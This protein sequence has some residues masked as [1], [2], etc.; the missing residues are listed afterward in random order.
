MSTSIVLRF[1]DLNVHLHA[2][3]K[4]LELYGEFFALA[5]GSG[6]TEEIAAELTPSPGGRYQLT[7]QGK[8]RGSDLDAGAALHKLLVTLR[9][10]AGSTDNGTL[11]RASA[12][13]WGDKSVLI[14]G[15]VTESGNIAAWLVAQ[16]FSYISQGYVR[17]DATTGRIEGFAGPMAI[18]ERALHE[19]GHMDA[20]RN[21]PSLR[22]RGAAY[23]RP[24]LG[25][26]PLETLSQ[27]ALILDVRRTKGTE[28]RL[29]AADDE[30][31]PTRLSWYSEDNAAANL[32]RNQ[33]ASALL[34]TVPT[35]SLEYDLVRAG[36]GIVD[37]FV[38]YV[39]EEGMTRQQVASLMG[40]MR[41]TTPDRVASDGKVLAPTSRKPSFRPRLTIGMATFDDYDGAYFSVQALRMYHPEVVD[42]AEILMIDNNPRGASA[43]YLKSLEKYADH[44]R[45][46]PEP[47]RVGTAVRDRIFSEA[48]GTYV[49][50]MDSHV[51]LQ[52]GALS[53]LLNYFEANP[54]SSD[55]I[56]GPIVWDNLRETS[57]HWVAEWKKGMLGTWA[58]DPVADDPTAPAF[59]IPMQGLGVFAC[60]RSAW[61]GFNAD[62]RGFG[63][64]EGY[65]HEKFRARGDRVICLPALRWLHRFNRP[66]G[67][68]YPIN[69]PDRIRNYLIGR[70]ELGL[71]ED[72][73][74]R[75]M[76]EFL[77][78]GYVNQV[79]ASLNLMPSPL[80]T[81]S[82]VP[83]PGPIEGS[84]SPTAEASRIAV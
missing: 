42:Q 19:L 50:C 69:W 64:E 52:P 38:R 28:I 29:S 44:F 77:G 75:H 59:E 6:G 48:S 60:R 67:I 46:I 16:G 70:R 21:Q 82:Q 71:P 13:G 54:E 56:Q 41:G 39:V 61:P 53:G 57:S 8:D 34:E 30:I 73:V 3:A 23:V 79:L 45:Y 5:L 1:F 35:I 18:G 7:V 66:T 55:L 4:L 26:S 40:A 15:P 74:I 17:V 32:V 9:Q 51:L 36:E 14:A 63:G 65:I 12:V 81:L 72:D 25:W 33:T 43:P 22:T 27:C 80:H 24:D 10:I 49:L 83:S 20:L 76:R 62:F 78:T 2:P 37:S 11:L 47:D 84:L 68:N 58:N 31:L